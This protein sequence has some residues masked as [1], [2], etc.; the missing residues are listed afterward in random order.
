MIGKKEPV[1]VA[2]V[3]AMFGKDRK[4]TLHTDKTT[5]LTVG[6][7]GGIKWDPTVN[8]VDLVAKRWAKY[9][10]RPVKS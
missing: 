6:S 10:I 3:P 1:C 9:Y 7:S 8:D 2:S 4:F 5:D